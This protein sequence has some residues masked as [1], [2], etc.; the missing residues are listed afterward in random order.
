MRRDAPEECV[1][2]LV[3][4]LRL[5]A[6]LLLPNSLAADALVERTL[7]KAIAEVSGRIEGQPL[8]AWLHQIMLAVFAQS[9]FGPN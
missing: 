7:E 2:Q 3:P 9:P 4:A 1:L 6:R 8:D 5:R